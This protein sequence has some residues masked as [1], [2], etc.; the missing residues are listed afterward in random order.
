M[1]EMIEQGRFW[2]YQGLGNDF[3]IVRVDAWP[4]PLWDSA[5]AQ[6]VCDRRFGVGADGVLVWAPASSPDADARMVIL[7]AD[8]S[9]PEMCGNGLRCFV[10]HLAYTLDP[11]GAREVWAVDT[12]AGKLTSRLSGRSP[13][14]A[15]GTVAVG[16]GEARFG[17]DAIDGDADLLEAD[18]DGRSWWVEAEGRRWRFVP[19]SMGNPHAVIVI[20]PSETTPA[21]D[22]ARRWGPGVGA[23]PAFRQ[24]VNVE[25]VR[26]DQATGALELAVYERGSGL[27]LACGTGACATVAVARRE[28][29]IEDVDA[30]TPVALPGGGLTVAVG[31][32]AAPGEGAL[33]MTG[34]AEL[35][36][37]G[38]WP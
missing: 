6:R 33:V 32:D 29:W 4:T 15:S 25:W 36:F 17:L 20:D 14:G 19:A 34:P 22:I 5:R 9:S 24:G 10:V 23:H 18:A 27:T 38:V 13:G 21:V 35:V 11:D 30:P 37:E 2:K 28:G 26:A 8:G 12:D 31:R 16:M 7:N 1:R 3:V